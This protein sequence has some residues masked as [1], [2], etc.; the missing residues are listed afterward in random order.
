MKVKVLT[1]PFTHN[2][3]DAPTSEWKQG[4]RVIDT[5]KGTSTFDL[6]DGPE[7]INPSSWQTEAQS[8]TSTEKKTAI[9]QL[10]ETGRSMHVRGK[11]SSVPAYENVRPYSDSV[12]SRLRDE[13]PYS[14]NEGSNAASWTKTSQEPSSDDKE[15]LIGYRAPRAGDSFLS[16]LGK[17]LADRL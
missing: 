9:D 4:L 11:K 5:S 1:V 17:D 3:V 15:N 8:A 14:L 2:S 6:I 12:A 13:N 10:T 16:G 7:E